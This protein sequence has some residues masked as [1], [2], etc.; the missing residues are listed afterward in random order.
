M[1]KEIL[2]VLASPVRQEIYD[3]MRSLGPTTVRQLAGQLEVPANSLYFHLKKMERAGIVKVV[4]TIKRAQSPPESIYDLVDSDLSFNF[5]VSDSEHA[6]LLITATAAMLR[7]CLRD[8]Q[9]A[10][11][12]SRT[13]GKGSKRNFRA[14]RLVAW[15]TVAETRKVNTLIEELS[16]ILQGSRKRPDANRFAVAWTMCPLVKPKVGH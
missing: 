14:A 11:R 15:L 16:E 5:D 1:E 4:E 8:F 9:S 6:G 13:V 2:R 3:L 12:S 10:S 7:L